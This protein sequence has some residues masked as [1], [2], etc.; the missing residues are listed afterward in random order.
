MWIDGLWLIYPTH[1][2]G[3]LECNHVV[4]I[5][6]PFLAHKGKYDMGSP[7][8][9]SG[10]DVSRPLEVAGFIRLRRLL[11]YCIERVHQAAVRP[12]SSRSRR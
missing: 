8:Y 4:W 12:G 2:L 1:L 7:G 10:R 6:L 11:F 5:S 9:E 3:G